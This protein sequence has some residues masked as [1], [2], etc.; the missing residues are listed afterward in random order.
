MLALQSQQRTALALLGYKLWLP[1]AE[2]AALRN[3]APSIPTPPPDTT[4]LAAAV[5]APTPIP[6]PVALQPAAPQAIPA[7][8]LILPLPD[9]AAQLHWGRDY[10]WLSGD[11]LSC[12]WLLPPPWAEAGQ[13][14]LFASEEERRLL[15]AL[16]A[17]TGSRE[18]HN[19]FTA[20]FTLARSQPLPLPQ[21]TATP[22]ADLATKPLLICSDTLCAQ[23]CTEP[24]VFGTPSVNA[25]NFQHPHTILADPSRKDGWWRQWIQIKRNLF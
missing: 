10:L 12:N 1:R 20:L 6:Q 22:P 14:T 8:P 24:A 13:P 5:P 7:E 21:A 23:W 4:V 3:A 15:L 11:D 25:Y 19:T 16:F 18:A 9:L 17:A 2:L